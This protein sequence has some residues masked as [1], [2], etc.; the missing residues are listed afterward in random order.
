MT[1]SEYLISGHID[2]GKIK[3]L[4]FDV[5]GTLSDTDDHLVNRLAPLLKP[6]A[7]LCKDQDPQHFARWMVMAAETPAN[8][9]YSLADRLGLDA[10]ITKLYDRMS[11]KTHE[12]KP[13]NER[14]W[15]IPGIKAMLD[16]LHRQFPL[17]VVSARDERTTL[18]F[19]E[20]FNL[21]PYFDVIVTAQTCDRTKPFPDPVECAAQQMGLSASQCVM[22]GDTIVD[23]LAGKSAGAQTIAVLCGFGTQR[24]LQRAGANLIVSSTADI[25]ALFEYK[26]DEI[27]SFRK[28]QP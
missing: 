8:F 10:S 7:W 27:P 25:T 17:A 1:P 23:V 3:G 9:M 19:L 5:D 20:H 26:S 16:N 24:E 18:Q 22:V 2:L 15:I 28:Q 21:L 6:F 11:R 4:L 12:H 14:F 13:L